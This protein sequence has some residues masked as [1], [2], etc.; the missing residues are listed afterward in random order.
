M[1]WT[2]VWGYIRPLLLPGTLLLIGVLAT[3]RWLIQKDYSILT[4]AIIVMVLVPLGA[5]YGPQTWAESFL[6]GI[7]S[8]DNEWRRQGGLPQRGV[9]NLP[10]LGSNGSQVY[11]SSQA[12]A[13]S[14]GSESSVEPT[15]EPTVTWDYNCWAR[16]A[17]ERGLTAPRPP[18]IP[19][20]GDEATDWLPKEAVC[21]FDEVSSPLLR[22]AFRHVWDLTCEGEDGSATLEISGA[23]ADNFG[24][25]V[26]TVLYG[27]GWVQECVEVKYPPTPTPEPTSPPEWGGDPNEGG[28]TVPSPTDTGEDCPA[29][30][31][32][33]ARCGGCYFSRMCGNI[34]VVE[35]SCTPCDPN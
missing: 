14:E 24:A 28:S 22:R 7:R 31:T 3:I 26:G 23:A 13:P 8:A 4:I 19:P 5:L 20:G 10:P 34:W 35:G 33:G 21:R 6:T 32:P 16:W 11:S 30:A 18:I 29:Q 15:A 1:W 27:T 25:K 9:D 2:E 12:A 17:Q